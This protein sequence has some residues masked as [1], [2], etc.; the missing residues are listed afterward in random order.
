MPTL[1]VI[2][3]EIFTVSPIVADLVLS[4]ILL[5]SITGAS[6]SAFVPVTINE[7]SF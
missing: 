5:K 4:L 1:S 2:F 6:E 3:I 7:Y